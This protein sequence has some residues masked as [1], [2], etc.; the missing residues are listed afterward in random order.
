MQRRE[1][2]RRRRGHGA[3]PGAFQPD[4]PRRPGHLPGRHRHRRQP[5]DRGRHRDDL[6]RHAAAARRPD[7]RP[8][9]REPLGH[10]GRG[11]PAGQL[12][13]HGQQRVGLD[14]RRAA[15]RGRAPAALPADRR[16]RRLDHLDLH[17]RRCERRAR[18]PRLRRRLD[19]RDGP[20]EPVPAPERALPV[21]AQRHVEQ[22]LRLP[23]GSRGR[24]A[25][26]GDADRDR[27]R[28]ALDGDPPE[29]QLRLRDQRDVERA[30]RLQHQPAERRDDAAR[31][32]DRDAGAAG[33]DGARPDRHAAAGRQP[34]LPAPR[35]GLRRRRRDGRR[36]DLEHAL[37]PQ[38]RRA[39]RDHVQPPGRLRVH[40][41]GELQRG[42]PGP[43]RRLDQD[44][45]ADLPGRDAGHALVDLGAPLG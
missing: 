9:H 18:A 43:G 16:Q 15:A 23:D 6:L 26:V 3:A 41:A 13:D 34:R 27:R 42:H 22:H 28:P 29:R 12:H 1:R 11:R 38:R 7:A 30:A 10:A 21:R 35:D 17:G 5:G 4:L 40:R 19:R 36:L 25:R 33:L 2:R 44:A 24:L 8:D 37:Q 20:R 39:D 32:A 45:H 14:Q 31:R